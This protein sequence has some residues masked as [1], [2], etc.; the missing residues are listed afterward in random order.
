MPNLPC[1]T[2]LDGYIFNLDSIYSAALAN[3]NNL[4]IAFTIIYHWIH[5]KQQMM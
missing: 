5:R 1:V 3:Q 4:L 2:R